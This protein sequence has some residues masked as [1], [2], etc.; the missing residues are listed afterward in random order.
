MKLMTPELAQMLPT[1]YETDEQGTNAVAKVKWFTPDAQW[2][3]YLTEYNPETGIGFGLVIGLECELG[4]FSKEE[5][6]AIRGP[7]GLPVERDLHFKPTPLHE[8][9][10]G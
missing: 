10:D 2:S 3:W 5:I 6:A 4:Y 1:L 8:L 9:M 7:L